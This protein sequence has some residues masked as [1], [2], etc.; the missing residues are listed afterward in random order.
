MVGFQQ[1]LLHVCSFYTVYR[2]MLVG[3]VFNETASLS[4]AGRISQIFGPRHK[5]LWLS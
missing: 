4:N 2:D 5:I 1:N 3:L